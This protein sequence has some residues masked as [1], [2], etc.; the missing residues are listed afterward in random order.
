[1]GCDQS[2][3]SKVTDVA[4]VKPSTPAVPES[5]PPGPVPAEPEV[6]ESAKRA[7]P[8]PI[9]TR[10]ASP[11][12]QPSPVPDD[13]YTIIRLLLLGSAESG[14]TTLLEQVRLLY[15][16]HFT[17]SEIFHRR[18]FIYNNLFKAIRS[19][20]IAM[21]D[22]GYQYDDPV[23]AGRAQ[24]LLEETDNH[25]GLFNADLAEKIKSVWRDAS[26]QKLYA[27]RSAFNLNDSAAYFLSNLDVINRP[28]YVPSE[29]DLIMSYVP[30]VGVQNVIFTANNQTFQLFDIGGQRIDRRKW[31]IHYDGIDAIF[32]CIAISEYDQLMNEDMM[33]NR[34]DDAL[35]LLEK[36]SKEPLFEKTMIYVFMNEVDVFREKISEIPLENFQ[37]D[38]K[39]GNAADALEFMEELVVKSL[40]N[41]DPSLYKIYQSVAIDTKLMKDI[42]ESVFKDIKKRKK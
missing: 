42:L 39:G 11:L 1:M 25:Y 15:K 22:H 16:Q 41:R 27:R 28:E 35:L 31:A 5:E 36:I 2:K 9:F 10:Q 29:K 32:F 4:T 26:V 24:V 30:T 23:N 6:V 37:L 14:K 18:M 34:L 40:A 33:T 7:S 19:L 21:N 17:E 8:S 12:P 38:F 3:S 13:N 20:V